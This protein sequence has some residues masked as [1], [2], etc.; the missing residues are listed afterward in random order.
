ADDGEEGRAGHARPRHGEDEG[1]DRPRPRRR[2]GVDRVADHGQGDE[3]EQGLAAAEV[4]AEEAAGVLVNAV[5]EVLE[6][7]V[8]AD[9]ADRRAEGSQILRE[10]LAPEVLAAGE[11]EHGG[12]DEENGRGR[13]LCAPTACV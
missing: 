8:E 9:R 3:E 5:E 4:I 1:D 7:A 2:G 6:A 13:T 10:E 11:E 12:G